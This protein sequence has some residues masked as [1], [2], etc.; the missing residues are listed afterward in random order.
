MEDIAHVEAAAQ[1][2]ETWREWLTTEIGKL[3]LTVT[4][5]VANF[6]LIH[7]PANG[8][9]H[10]EAADAHLKSRGIILRRVGAYGL[11]NALRMTVGSE[12]DNRATV[13]A[14]AE[15]MGTRGS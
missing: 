12:A 1:H 11:P 10:A 5:S 8:A 3:G 9:R 2:N 14:L 4:P 13:A 7:F 6:I 15:F